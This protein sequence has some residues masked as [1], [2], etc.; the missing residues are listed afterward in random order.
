LSSADR[1]RVVLRFIFRDWLSKNAAPPDL[2]LL[3]L[4]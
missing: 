1:W 4:G 2:T 3:I